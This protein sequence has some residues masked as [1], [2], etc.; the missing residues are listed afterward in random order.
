MFYRSQFT[1]PD[2]IKLKSYDVLLYARIKRK[3]LSH[4]ADAFLV[5][6]GKCAEYF[7]LACERG[8]HVVY[9]FPTHEKTHG[10]KRITNV[11]V[12]CAHMYN[13]HQSRN[14]INTCTINV[15]VYDVYI[16]L[17]F[18][19]STNCNCACVWLRCSSNFCF[20]DKL[21]L[22]RNVRIDRLLT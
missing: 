21:Y 6:Q 9:L 1:D 14:F 22:F 2:W 19:L 3:I 10:V 5:N 8:V 16:N 13:V 7:S 15:H 4:S 12:F 18:V 11:I 20:M 17:L